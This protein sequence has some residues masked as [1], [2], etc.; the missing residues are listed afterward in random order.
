MNSEK[1]SVKY[2]ELELSVITPDTEQSR[3]N[4]DMDKLLALSDSIKKNGVLQPII[5]RSI[6]NKN[7]QIIAGERRYRAAL[8]AGITKIPA[9]ISKGNPYE[10][11]LIENLQRVDLTPIEEA[12]A[13]LKMK[14]VHNYKQKEICSIIGKSQATI[15]ETLSINKLPDEIKQEVT[16]SPI[17]RRI[18]VEIAKKKTKDEMIFLFEEVKSKN[19]SSSDLKKSNKNMSNKYRFRSTRAETILKKAKNLRDTILKLN[20]EDLDVTLKNK[21][22]KEFKLLGHILSQYQS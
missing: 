7:F 21:I 22:V 9:L 11:A 5:V 8:M 4:F 19:L 12:E 17:S 10:I 16:A 2:V 18:L 15:S 14:T 13:L 3:K 20:I 1:K 6:L